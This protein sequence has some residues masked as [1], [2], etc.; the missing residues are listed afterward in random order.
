MTFWGIS[1]RGDK[2]LLGEPSAAV[3][4]YDSA[5]P[6]DMLKVN[7]PADRIWE[8]LCELELCQN[9]QTLFCGIVDEQNTTISSSGLTVELICRSREALLLDNEAEPCSI[10]SPSLA[11]LEKK[12]LQPLGLV[13]GSGDKTSKPG[14]LIVA[15]G[16][17][18]W[19]VLQR[20]CSE[21]MGTVPYVDTD[22]TV[23][24]GGQSGTEVELT[25]IISA[26]IKRRPYK[27]ISEVWQQSCRGSYDTLYRGNG[28][29][30][31]RRYISMQSGKNPHS[32]L[33]AGEH[34]ALLII[35]SCVGA[36]WV[37]RGC[38]ASVKLPR[39]G[40]LEHCPVDS[41]KYS[42]DKNGERTT[43]TLGCPEN[44]KGEYICG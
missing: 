39:I 26:E 40:R 20:F 41:V 36:Q 10:R 25:D 15:K 33:N 24:C 35:V 9:G 4:S 2:F 44:L 8:P 17:S 28:S 31:R 5:A 34:D 38:T 18:V 11:A 23:Q 32:V 7:F 16:E 1:E 14:E 19:S 6:A 42:R 3:M 27:L 22:G 30:I 21:Y 29:V 37:K 13:L 12:L 43:L